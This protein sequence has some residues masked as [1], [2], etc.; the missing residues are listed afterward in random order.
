MAT[1]A[2]IHSC[3]RCERALRP[4][5]N[6]ADAG[7]A[8][9]VIGHD[10][11]DLRGVRGVLVGDVFAG[12]HRPFASPVLFVAIVA[13]DYAGDV[14]LGV[15]LDG[16][17]GPDAAV[18]VEER[19]GRFGL[20]L[21]DLTVRVPL[22]ELLA[23]AEER[24]GDVAGGVVVFAGDGVEDGGG[25]LDGDGMQRHDETFGEGLRLGCGVEA[26]GK[27]PAGQ[28]GLVV[29]TGPAVVVH[30][31][32]DPE[33]DVAAVGLECVEHQIAFAEGDNVVFAA[34]EEPEGG[35]ADGAGVV[36][37]EGGGELPA[38]G[39]VAPEGTAGDDGDGRPAMGFLPGELPCA[40]AAHGEAGEV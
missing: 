4:K 22:V 8:V 30:A 36:A 37:G 27:E 24:G 7:T 2:A 3:L 10:R 21:G 38:L 12:Q 33:A 39:R 25:E 11:W 19:V 6:Y 40:V 18:G 20:D 17:S 9:P 13:E 28:L 31:C 26:V 5:C 23:L 15:V 29:G 14:A 34:M 1:C 32:V 35:A 16:A